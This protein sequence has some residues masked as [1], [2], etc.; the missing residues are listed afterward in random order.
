MACQTFYRL[1]RRSDF[2]WKYL[3]NLGPYLVHNRLK[4]PMNN[5][6]EELVE[7]LKR[8]GIAI[9]S[10][11]NI[12]EDPALFEELEEKVRLLELGLNEKIVKV[13]RDVNTGQENKMYVIKLLGNRPVLDPNSVFA[14]F[15]LHPHIMSLVNSYMGMLSKLRGYSVWRNI[16]TRQVARESQLWHRD[17]EDRK[18]LKMFVY[19]SE[20]DSESGPFNFLPKT[21]SS[22]KLKREPK[23]TLIKE[24]ETSVRRVTDEDM[25]VIFPKGIWVSAEGPKGT[26]IFADTSGYH[27]GGCCLNNERLLFTCTYTS[28]AS[29]PSGDDLFVRRTFEQKFTDPRMEFAL[30]EDWK[31]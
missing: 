5:F 2:T 8:D 25:E 9:T 17:P 13:R 16:P 10:V 11:N 6:Q 23:A 15:A 1:C 7:S 4:E 30:R 12:L 29:G 19:L 21:H 18:I 14:R 22:Y 31:I 3:A 24:G 28:Q 27:K 26:V 20:V